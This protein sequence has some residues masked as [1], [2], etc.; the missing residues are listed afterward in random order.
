MMHEISDDGGGDE[1]R[2]A[3]K[4]HP[5]VISKTSK[6]DNDRKNM[7]CKLSAAT[8]AWAMI[9]MGTAVS[10]FSTHRN[11]VTFPRHVQQNYAF[12]R[13]HSRGN[14]RFMFFADETEALPQSITKVMPIDGSEISVYNAAKFMVDSFWLQSPQQLVQTSNDSIPEISDEIKSKLITQQ[15]DDIMKNYG[16]RLGRRKLEAR[17]FIASSDGVSSGALSSIENVQGMVTIEVRLLKYGADTGR[18]G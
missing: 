15:A 3:N 11:F 18:G 12:V 4:L 14:S 8:V 17:L 6:L 13:H 5:P 2:K 16:E 10:S 9:A 1:A 7:S